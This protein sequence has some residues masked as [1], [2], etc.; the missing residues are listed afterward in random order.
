MV[1]SKDSKKKN[2]VLTVVIGLVAVAVFY[3]AVLWGCNKQVFDFELRF[4][5]AMVR[6]PDGKTEVIEIQK[7]NDYEGDQIQIITSDNV[8]LFHCNNVV[9]MKN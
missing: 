9:L 5:K 6:W 7:W 8:Y 2:G 1:D 3:F 4:T